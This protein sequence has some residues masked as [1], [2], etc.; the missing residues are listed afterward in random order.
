MTTQMTR[1]LAKE[2]HIK[3]NATMAQF[4]KENGLTFVQGRASYGT[5]NFAMKV[6]LKTSSES[7]TGV[8]TRADRLAGGL[9]EMAKIFNLS[10]DRN[11]AGKKLVGYNP[12]GR[13]YPWVFE[14]P[15]GGRWK[16]THDQVIN[17]FQK[18]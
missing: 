5:D 17:W 14:G 8:E 1:S 11:V 4:A 6:E 2:L 10:L 13:T 7:S 18:A 3:L 12:K 9:E 16:A 15:Q